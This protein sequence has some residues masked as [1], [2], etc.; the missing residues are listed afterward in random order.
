MYAYNPQNPEQNIRKH[1]YI[2][3]MGVKAYLSVIIKLHSVSVIEARVFFEFD[4]MASTDASKLPLVRLMYE[5]R[6]SSHSVI[7]GIKP[8]RQQY[9]RL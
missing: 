4:S 5:E 1:N 2:Y 3:S 9:I 6:P 7:G 8:N